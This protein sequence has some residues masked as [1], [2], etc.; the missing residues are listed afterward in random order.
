MCSKAR[1]L[2]E[3]SKETIRAAVYTLPTTLATHPVPTVSTSYSPTKNNI[4][5][6]IC[7]QD[8]FQVRDMPRFLAFS[9]CRV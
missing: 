3:E 7:T 2:L 9:E 6:R 5:S 8:V 1:K 4:Y